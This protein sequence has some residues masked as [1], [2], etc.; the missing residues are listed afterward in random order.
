MYSIFGHY[1]PPHP[2]SDLNAGAAQRAAAKAESVEQRIER[3]LLTAEAMWT[4]L[5]ERLQLT[6][7]QLA[8]RIVELDES[9]GLLDGRVRRPPKTC[10]HC[11]KTIPARFPR[12][13]YCGET[14][15]AEPFA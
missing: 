7:D 6:D 4:L 1:R 10:P 3:A 14:V 15:P 11:A 12:C 5:R 8:R 9:D 13:I 2:G